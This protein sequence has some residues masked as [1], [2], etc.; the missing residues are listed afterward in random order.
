MTTVDDLKQRLTILGLD[1]T[2]N[3]TS[4]KMRLRKYLKK[5]PDAID[6]LKAKG[7]NMND[8][9]DEDETLE[10]KEEEVEDTKE[11][12]DTSTLKKKK[13]QAT[14]V[15]VEEDWMIEKP[16]ISP[17]KNSRY[18]YYLCFDVEATCEE[19]F[20]FEFPNEVIEFPVVLMDGSTFEIV[21][22]FH[23]YVRPVHRPILSDFCKSLTGI[24]QETVD[25]APIFTEVLEQFNEFLMKHG[26]IVGEGSD[27]SSKGQESMKT[28]KKH[29]KSSKRRNNHFN[30]KDPNHH[31]QSNAANDDFIYGA[32]F[33]FI[34]DGPF[35]IR[36]FIGKQCLI[37]EI[38]RPSYFAVPYIDIRTM[39]KEYFDLSQRHNLEGMLTFLGEKFEGRQHSGIC[40]ARMVGLIAKRLALG[41]SIENNDP[42]FGDVN[43]H[44]VLP[45][46]SKEKIKKLA[47][48]CVLKSNRTTE[49]TFVKMMS[50]KRIEKIEALARGETIEPESHDD[51]NDTKDTTKG[52]SKDGNKNE[53]S[54]QDVTESTAGPSSSSSSQVSR[55]STLNGKIIHAGKNK[56]EDVLLPKLETSLETLSSSPTSPAS[57]ASPASESSDDLPESLISESRFSALSEIV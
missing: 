50:F 33:C 15:V 48:G 20:S 4:V 46:W 8:D 32:S 10:K 41:F 39:L 55:G 51:D 25:A 5:N 7:S 11:K 52:G 38:P 13:P 42:V 53:G 49:Q 27:K 54:K 2:G 16:V 57:P 9:I 3:K 6:I 29:S 24:T 28:Q 12:Q 44:L 30:A 31:Q 23:S 56:K 18:D 1:T 21:D 37:S 34:T 22:E 35:D 19:G 43:K 14:P 17:S 26:I 36:D 45:Q 40:D 47:G